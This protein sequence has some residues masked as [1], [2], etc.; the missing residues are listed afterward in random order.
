MPTVL[1]VII[2]VIIRGNL[3]NFV[4]HLA[5]QGKDDT[6]VG[7]KREKFKSCRRR[8]RTKTA[9]MEAVELEDPS[10]HIKA[11]WESHV[12]PNSF[13]PYDDG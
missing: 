9:E 5:L 4:L 11:V 12:H 3:N 7:G 2:S 1:V 10:A 6:P 8:K 13:T